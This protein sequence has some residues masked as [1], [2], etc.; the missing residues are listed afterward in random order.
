[1]GFWEITAGVRVPQVRAGG[2]LLPVRG[3]VWR[4]CRRWLRLGDSSG[5][6]QGAHHG[7]PGAV[8]TWLV[9][10]SSSLKFYGPRIGALY[11]RGPGTTTPLHPMLFGGGQERSFRPG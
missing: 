11:V 6:G 8:P 7:A 4:G 10:L 9:Q 2:Q 5:V 3:F 1:M